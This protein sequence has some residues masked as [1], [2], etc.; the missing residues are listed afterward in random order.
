MVQKDERETGI[1]ANLNFGHTFAHALESA[2]EYD[3]IKHGE[4]VIAGMICALKLSEDKLSDSSF[5][6]EKSFLESLYKFE[7]SKK[8]DVENLFELMKHDKK[9][10]GDEI[11]L[12]L[13]ES[14]GKAYKTSEYSKNQITK[15]FQEIL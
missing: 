6:E 2:G 12:I 10:V 5:E 4:A 13:L 1:R 3:F 14:I 11:N 15:A 9:N 7:N 8:F